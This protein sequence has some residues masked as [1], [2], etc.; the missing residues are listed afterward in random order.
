MNSNY[1]IRPA[2]AGEMDQVG[3]M[4]AYVYAGAFGDGA[5]NITATSIRPEWTLCAFDGP[6]LITSFATFPFTMRAN[7]TAMKFGGVTAVGTLPEY[8][9]QGLVRKIMTAAIAQQREQGQSVAGLWASQAA[10]YQRYGYAAAGYNRR[11]DIDSVSIRFADGEGGSCEVVRKTPGAGVDEAREVYR[12]FIAHRFGYL[13]R[14]QILWQA[15]VLDSA[16]DGPV[17]LA[18]AY[19]EGKVCGYV[20]YT[21]RA[22]KVN[23]AARSQ[24]IKIRDLGWLHMDAYRSIWR[25]LSQH[26]LV[27]SVLW[28]NAPMDDPAPQIMLEPRLLHC[29]DLEGS[30]MRLID[31]PVALAGRGYDIADEGEIVIGVDGD[32]F[33]DW[34][35]GNWRLQYGG[36]EVTVS[37]SKAKPDAQFSIAALTALYTGMYSARELAF[38]ERI[39]CSD[40]ATLG[41]LDQLFAT[42][43]K[44]HCPD[45]Y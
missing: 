36:G 5:D 1:A 42:R 37:P 11:Y 18:L 41:Q 22:N 44:P 21:L 25:Y 4:A 6:K 29:R 34:N 23:N 38:A 10:I 19:N 14:S 20:A 32:E 9:R 13:H 15:N 39:M 7:G 26:D 8:R 30:W 24:Q 43:F 3:L 40:S 2:T 12:S 35:N 45:H 28:E 17:H 31:V 16:D 33:A 27:G